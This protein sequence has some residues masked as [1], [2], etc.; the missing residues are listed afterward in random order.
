[1]G[2]ALLKKPDPLQIPEPNIT[3][4]PSASGRAAPASAPTY[5]EMKQKAPVSQKQKEPE[6]KQPAQNEQI[7][8]GTDTSKE[9][10]YEDALQVTVPFGD[11]KGKT[12]EEVSKINPKDI[13][14]LATAFKGKNQQLKRAAQIIWEK[15]QQAATA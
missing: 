3:P 4:F 14:W 1:M 12:L 10:T 15:A 11:N 8:M 9:M 2:M 13:E 7:S 6:E 5:E